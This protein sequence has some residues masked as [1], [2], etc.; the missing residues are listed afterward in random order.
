MQKSASLH[1][2]IKNT[3]LRSTEKSKIWKPLHHLQGV[4]LGT[5]ELKLLPLLSYKD[6][7]TARPHS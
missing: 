6:L 2:E 4:F 5:K 1:A 7:V 3:G